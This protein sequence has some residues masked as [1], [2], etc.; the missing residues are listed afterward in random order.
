M[1]TLH[2]SVKQN[3]LQKMDSIVSMIQ[4]LF[5]M[6]KWKEWDIQIEN[7]PEKLESR[8][9]AVPE[10]IHKEGDDQKL[11]CSERLLKQMPVFNS[12]ALS[13]KQIVVFYDE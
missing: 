11:F 5:K 13:Q 1:R 12:N 2:G 10:L 7:K 8:R 3:T 6:S 4:N 9:L